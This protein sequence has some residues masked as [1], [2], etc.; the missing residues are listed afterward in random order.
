MK[1]EEKNEKTQKLF[2]GR[3]IKRPLIPQSAIYDKSSGEFTQKC[4]LYWTVYHGKKQTGIGKEGFKSMSSA[5]KNNEE[6]VKVECSEEI[7]LSEITRVSENHKRFKIQ[8]SDNI[9]FPVRRVWSSDN[10]SNKYEGDPVYGGDGKV[11]Y[12]IRYE[13]RNKD[14]RLSEALRTVYSKF[15]ATLAT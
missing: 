3:I 13:F 11:V 8:V 1:K 2:F 7:K 4:P 5:K 14:V 15:Y 12:G 9:H 6:S 10:K